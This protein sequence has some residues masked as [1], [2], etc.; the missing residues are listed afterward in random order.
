MRYVAHALVFIVAVVAGIAAGIPGLVHR[1][2]TQAEAKLEERLGVDV[3]VESVDWTFDGTL[4]LG[5]VTISVRDA[6][7]GEP[8]LMT[9][10]RIRVDSDVRY[11]ARKVKLKSIVAHEPVF[12]VV[13]RADGSDN[14]R[15]V[16]RRALALLRGERSEGG[17]GGGGGGLMRLLDRS[18]TPEVRFEAL[19]VALDAGDTGLQELVGIPRVL[20]LSKGLLHLRN[21][22]VLKEDPV[23]EVKLRFGDTSLDPGFGVTLASEFRPADDRA[24]WQAP[25]DL[26]FDRPARVTV[27]T[28]VAAVGGLSWR[29]DA[30]AP[31]QVTEVA[32]SVP[33]THDELSG[34]EPV[35]PAVEIDAVKISLGALSL[36][37]IAAV[38]SAAPA[39]RAE[40]ARG[41]IERLGKLELVKPA[42]V[43]ERTPGGHNFTDLVGGS[44]TRRAA[45]A[46]GASREAAGPDKALGILM[47]ATVDAS[48]R[49]IEGATRR[50]ADGARFRGWLKRGINHLDRRVIRVTESV[51][52]MAKRIPFKHLVVTRGHFQ[53]RDMR[54]PVPGQ[55]R[56]Q[57]KL[58]NFDLTATRADSLL[59]FKAAFAIPDRRD[60]GASGRKGTVNEVEGKVHQLTGDTQL[61]AKLGHLNLHP[62]RQAFPASL[63][64]RHDTAL[65][66]TDLTVV[67]SQSTEIARIEGKLG[68]LNGSF[69][70]PSLASEALQGLDVALNFGAQLDRKRKTLVLRQSDMTIGKAKL[71]VRADVAQFDTSPKVSAAFRLER[72]RAQDVVD[73]LPAQM[74]PLLEGM[75]VSGT[76]AWHLDFSLDTANMETLV[77]HSYP[78][79]NGFRVSDMG[80]R[81]NLTAVRGSFVHRIEEADGTKREMLIGP[82][83]TYWTPLHAISE[84]VVKGVTTT[85]DGAFFRHSGFSPFAIRSSLVANLKKG[86]FA[87]GASTISQQLVKNLFLSREKTISR[88][89]QELFITSQLEHALSKE[90]IMELYLNVIEWGPG[91][92]G[93]RHAA[94][95]YF[96]KRAS[97]LTPLEAVFLVS[98]IPNPKKYYWQFKRGEVTDGWRRHLRWIMSVMRDRG[99][100]SEGTYQAAAP[101]S[102]VFRGSKRH[103]L[104]QQ[105]DAPGEGTAS[106]AAP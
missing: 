65:T 93:V 74:I 97:E 36:G 30:R 76:V 57:Q 39:D 86:R 51:L 83:S 99:K 101:Y 106:A 85:E 21:T 43:F 92:Y 5:G 71:K 2:G 66:D 61:R 11:S 55:L 45:K 17:A 27:G 100:I 62:Y 31:L 35:A 64:V 20:N 60:G 102:P 40:A 26:T 91:I 33:L 9:A 77:Y 47:T 53:W 49:L 95:H 72:A 98:L 94:R 67:W 16:A 37:D 1:L 18:T 89:L 90:R 96:G 38:A 104:E 24:W 88:K 44:T 59:T 34:A 22:S 68:V 14:V 13:R 84:H 75:K 103:Q 29:A 50:R 4:E 56:L 28:R 6:P 63:R 69:H 80:K 19:R 54:A 82:G 79:V 105:A 32:L 81:L 12:K 73:S 7:T 41:L 25:L 46:A 10:S 15:G 52:A 3:E 23:F 48:A 42:L 58:E 70:Y 87:R 8:P 78:E